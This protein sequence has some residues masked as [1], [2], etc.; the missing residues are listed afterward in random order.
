MLIACIYL[1]VFCRRKKGFNSQFL[2]LL[3]IF[4]KMSPLSWVLNFGRRVC[5]GF[6][7]ACGFLKNISCDL[8]EVFVI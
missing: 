2:Y 5:Y 6:C 8:D 1:F 3:L 7:G 4:T